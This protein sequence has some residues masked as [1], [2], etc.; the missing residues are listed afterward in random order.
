M[1][2]SRIWYLNN[3]SAR[4]GS[5]L[6]SLHP[7]ARVVVESGAIY[8]SMLIILLILYGQKS[9]FQYV[10]VDAVSLASLFFVQSMLKIDSPVIINNRKRKN[11]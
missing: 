4:S 3:Q 8:S 1:I 6:S 5:Q 11:S 2:A 10:I 7:I 9:W